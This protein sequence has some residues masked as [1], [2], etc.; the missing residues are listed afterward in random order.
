[1]Q[2]V[3]GKYKGGWITITNVTT[4]PPSRFEEST[5][6]SAGY[7]VEADVKLCQNWWVNLGCYVFLR[8][9]D[10]DLKYSLWVE[11]WL[12]FITLS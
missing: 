10:D 7:K 12:R 5:T 3:S 6:S 1:M 8:V 4:S 2:F 9:K 11:N